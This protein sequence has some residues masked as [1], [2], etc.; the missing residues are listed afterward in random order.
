MSSKLKFAEPL[1][2]YLSDKQAVYKL[3]LIGPAVVA[4]AVELQG[5]EAVEEVVGDERY[6]QLVERRPGAPRLDGSKLGLF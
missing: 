3:T 6:H 5:E 1:S 2:H 4:E